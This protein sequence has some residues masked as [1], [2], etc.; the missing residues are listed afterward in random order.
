MHESL[1]AKNTLETILNEAKNNKA[2]KV[3]KA[4]IK[5]SDTEDLS[6]ESFKFHI[7]NYAQGTIAENMEV[8]LNF[9]QIPIVCNDCGNRFYSDSHIYLCDNCGSEN[10]YSGAEEGI[11]IEYIDLE[12]DESKI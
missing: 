10:T 12:I 5:I 8:E 11:I 9:I 1:L 6:V 4:K 3:I 7:K 2:S